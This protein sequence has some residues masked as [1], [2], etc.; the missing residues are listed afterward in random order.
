MSCNDNLPVN[1]F[2]SSLELPSE[3]KY[4]RHASEEISILSGMSNDFGKILQNGCSQSKQSIIPRVRRVSASLI[5]QL[6]NYDESEEKSFLEIYKDVKMMSDAWKAKEIAL[7]NSLE[8]LGFCFIWEIQQIRPIIDPLAMVCYSWLRTRGYPFSMNSP[9][10]WRASSY[11]YLV[12]HLMAV[13]E[14]V[15]LE[16]RDDCKASST[17]ENMTKIENYCS[18]SHQQCDSSQQ[19]VA[20][21]VEIASPSSFSKESNH[22]T[23]CFPGS[24]FKDGYRNSDTEHREMNDFNRSEQQSYLSSTVRADVNPV[25]LIDYSLIRN[26]VNKQAYTNEELELKLMQAFIE[27]Q[28]RSDPNLS[29]I[30]IKSQLRSRII[31]VS[32]DALFGK[33]LLSSTSETDVITFFLYISIRM[34]SEAHEGLTPV[35][36]NALYYPQILVLHDIPPHPIHVPDSTT[37]YQPQNVLFT[38]IIQLHFPVETAVLQTAGLI[39]QNPVPSW[40][41]GIT[42]KNLFV[43]AAICPA[44][45]PMVIDLDQNSASAFAQIDSLPLETNVHHSVMLKVMRRSKLPIHSFDEVKNIVQE[46]LESNKLEGISK[47]KEIDESSQSLNKDDLRKMTFF[48][49]FPLPQIQVDVGQRVM[50]RLFPHKA[51]FEIISQ[52][53]M[54]YSN[55]E[56][57]RLQHIKESFFQSAQTPKELMEKHQNM[58]RQAY[59]ERN[60]DTSFDRFAGRMEF[61]L[62]NSFLM[63]NSITDEMTKE[64]SNPSSR[65]SDS[66]SDLLSSSILSLADLRSIPNCRSA[67]TS[68]QTRATSVFFTNSQRKW[69]EWFFNKCPELEE[70]PNK[71]MLSLNRFQRALLISVILPS[72]FR[73]A[74]KLAIS[75][76]QFTGC[77]TAYYSSLL[78]VARGRNFMGLATEK[79]FRPSPFF[80][81][82]ISSLEEIIKPSDP[83]A[84]RYVRLFNG[85][86]ATSGRIISLAVQSLKSTDTIDEHRVAKDISALGE[87]KGISTNVIRISEQYRNSKKILE[88]QT[89]KIA[90][91][92]SFWELAWECTE[93]SLNQFLAEGGWIVIED[94]HL[95]TPIFISHFSKWIEENY[96]PTKE[97][98]VDD[99]KNRILWIILPEREYKK[100]LSCLNNF[101]LSVSMVVQRVSIRP[102]CTFRGNLCCA[103]LSNIS[104]KSSDIILRTAHHYDSSADLNSII[105]K[106]IIHLVFTL[107]TFTSLVI[108]YFRVYGP[109][110]HF[111]KFSIPN[112]AHKDVVKLIT[113]IQAQKFKINS[114]RNDSLRKRNALAENWAWMRIHENLRERVFPFLLGT[115]PN[116]VFQ[117]LCTTLLH[118]QLFVSKTSLPI[119][120]DVPNPVLDNGFTDLSQYLR[121]IQAGHLIERVD[122]RFENDSCQSLQCS[123]TEVKSLVEYCLGSIVGSN[124]ALSPLLFSASG[125]LIDMQNENLAWRWNMHQAK[126]QMMSINSVSTAMTISAKRSRFTVGATPYYHP[127]IVLRICE[128]ITSLLPPL[129]FD[130]NSLCQCTGIACITEKNIPPTFIAM[131][132]EAN[133]QNCCLKQLYQ[134]LNSLPTFRTT[135]DE[136]SKIVVEEGA[137]S[138]PLLM[139][140]FINQVNRTSSTS[141]L[142]FSHFQQ[143]YQ[144]SLDGEIPDESKFD[145]DFEYFTSSPFN[146]EI[147]FNTTTNSRHFI[148][149]WISLSCGQVP[150]SWLVLP[151]DHTNKSSHIL[152]ASPVRFIL[153]WINNM[154]ASFHQLHN[155]F[156]F[157]PVE[158]R[159]ADLTNYPLPVNSFL[160]HGEE[161]MRK[162]SVILPPQIRVF[163]AFICELKKEITQALNSQEFKLII[164]KMKENARCA[165]STTKSRKKSQSFPLQSK[166]IHKFESVTSS[167][168]IQVGQELLHSYQAVHSTSSNPKSV[169]SHFIKKHHNIF[170]PFAQTKICSETNATSLFPSSRV[171]PL[172]LKFSQ[173]SYEKESQQNK[174]FH[175]NYQIIEN[176]KRKHG[177]CDNCCENEMTYSNSYLQE[178]NELISSANVYIILV[179][180]T[181]RSLSD[182]PEQLVSSI[183]L[184]NL[185]A[186]FFGGMHLLCP[187]SLSFDQKSVSIQ[188][189]D[190]PSLDNTFHAVASSKSSSRFSQA[191]S[192]SAVSSLLSSSHDITASS[193]THSFLDFSVPNPSKIIIS[194][195][196]ADRQDF[197]PPSLSRTPLTSC[198]LPFMRLCICLR[199]RKGQFQLLNG[200]VL[201]AR[202]IQSLHA[203]CFP[204]T[205]SGFYR[206]FRSVL[207]IIPD[208]RATSSR[209]FCNGVDHSTAVS[210]ELQGSSYYS[211]DKVSF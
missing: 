198:G 166:V 22:L 98:Y 34:S 41:P 113:N 5:V 66:S 120:T 176:S 131:L 116:S 45:R 183:K 69:G 209:R 100:K 124:I 29:S 210:F 6:M 4:K 49:P 160:A 40:L 130:I 37:N 203:L 76:Q 31:R 139:P 108:E 12:G 95:A 133:L 19:I 67:T 82:G 97:Y 146:S 111:H 101:S 134:F 161:V 60:E 191:S 192:F 186:L 72:R 197:I 32:L 110:L 47:A 59:E 75:T 51:P 140:D 126:M 125:D 1:S 70:F 90:S 178:S 73:Q 42:W 127:A 173:C 148:S 119:T 109:T 159:F 172:N 157:V 63:S 138:A 61:K 14:D 143:D 211:M 20:K 99:S 83:L 132:R 52:K 106:Q 128:E 103:L 136:N 193:S 26:C 182:L 25:S 27:T 91:F 174:L 158:H 92:E 205:L 168:T 10:L 7:Q 154:I 17:E 164:E 68:S 39:P 123:Q 185:F 199:N 54:N 150:L 149:S 208:E 56:F 87:I 196:E 89:S 153:Q 189:T 207:S 175:D 167:N 30:G 24:S 80:Y 79:S 23:G 187:Q 155:L 9:H 118:P 13:V 84:N 62:L 86:P 112:K 114:R 71:Q 144:F 35:E 88:I 177:F 190:Y 201:D 169:D 15:T 3:E 200:D 141:S 137:C 77:G 180:S 179:P 2:S 156:S 78:P 50:S 85:R 58:K 162:P 145:L 117:S 18:S 170:Q 36:L 121:A 206:P 204:V 105:H 202:A 33:F 152:S 44:F 142:S 102:P 43:L 147:A 96:I 165:L 64:M 38:E 8:W 81:C 93:K 181:Y 163:G 115:M 151:Q 74:A 16:E 65:Q 48:S 135:K 104:K 55:D 57:Q 94:L 188:R 195:N 129:L 21:N 171:N 53:D 11:H 184:R 46:I 122:F 194:Y 107:I 28:I